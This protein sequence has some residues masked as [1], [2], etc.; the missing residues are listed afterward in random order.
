MFSLSR[1]WALCQEL[2]QKKASKKELTVVPASEALASQFKHDFTLIACMDITVMGGM[3]YLDISASFHM[4]G[5]KDLFSDFE[6]KDL[7]KNIEFGDDGRYST[8]RLGIVTFER[9]FGSP[10]RI[11]YVMYVPR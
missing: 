8:T 10:L 5:N 7:K 6:E 1:A 9:D 4:I 2:P 11:T 3:F